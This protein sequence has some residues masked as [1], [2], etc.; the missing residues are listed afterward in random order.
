MPRRTS[1]P[2]IIQSRWNSQDS[3]RPAQA[4]STTHSENHEDS[5]A[6]QAEDAPT[7]TTTTTEAEAHRETQPEEQSRDDQLD[8][9][10]R[11]SSGDPY[12]DAVSLEAASERGDD[13]AL[14]DEAYPRS[15]RHMEMFRKL[16]RMTEPKE[17]VF[18]GNLFFDVT[19]EDMRRR[20]EKFG[21]V[22][23]VYIV[24]DN[25]GISKG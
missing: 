13:G 19:A 8:P 1:P 24:R 11:F 25:R 22:Q 20:M 4:Q 15:S 16:Q 5:A 9:Q 7:T 12:Y 6:R 18:M 17:T 14:D 10:D 21:V 3:Q 23:Q 2:S